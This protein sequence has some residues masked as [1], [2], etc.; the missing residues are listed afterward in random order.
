MPYGK[1]DMILQTFDKYKG[2][3]NLEE[4]IEIAF[5]GYKAFS[6]E[7]LSIGMMYAA[8]ATGKPYSS[9]KRQMIIW[10]ELKECLLTGHE[11]KYLKAVGV[12]VDLKPIT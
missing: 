9:T 6:P 5:N 3:L 10:A 12:E 2:R 1:S 11:A 8:L 4:F 7:G